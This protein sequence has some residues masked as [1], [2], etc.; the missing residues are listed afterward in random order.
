MTSLIDARWYNRHTF[1]DMIWRNNVPEFSPTLAQ[2]CPPSLLPLHPSSSLRTALSLSKT[3]LC[4]HHYS[5]LKSICLKGNRFLD[6]RCQLKVFIGKT[7]PGLRNS[8]ILL[9]VI[10]ILILRDF[11]AVCLL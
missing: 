8:P 5:R 3:S 2:H 7:S 1:K 11:D 9:D 6:G 4:R 10:A